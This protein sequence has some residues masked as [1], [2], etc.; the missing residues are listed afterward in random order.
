MSSSLFPLAVIISASLPSEPINISSG[1]CL[2]SD[3]GVAVPLMVCGDIGI[4]CGVAVPL[5]VCGDIPKMLGSLGKNLRLCSS[6]VC[7]ALSIAILAL[8]CNCV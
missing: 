3:C 7:C 6:P 1:S 4:D 5:I 8:S 2:G